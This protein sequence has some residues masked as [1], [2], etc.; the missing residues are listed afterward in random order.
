MIS[1]PEAACIQ[2][3]VKPRLKYTETHS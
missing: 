2:G 1:V 3:M